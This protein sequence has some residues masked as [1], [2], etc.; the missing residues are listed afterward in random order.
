M[1]N[2]K[3]LYYAGSEFLFSTEA[4]LVNYNSWIVETILGPMDVSQKGKKVLD[5]G[6]GI[7]TLSSIFERQTGIKPEGLEI[8]PRQREILEKRGFKVYSSFNEIE[9]KYD[10]IF[11]SN[12]LEHI[13]DDV[14]ILKKLRERIQESGVLAIYVPAFQSIW[15]SLD[16][17]V[18]HYRRYTK[19]DLIMKLEKSGF[20]VSQSRYCDSVGFFLT[21]L[22]KLIGN[23]DGE[24]SSWTL[25]VFDKYLLPIS[26][27]LDGIFHRLLGKN[28]FVLAH[29]DS[30]S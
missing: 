14:E 27:V 17:K 15:S 3:Q 11:T 4:D 7:G 24:P 16:D 18:G 20:T 10:F 1:Q 2:E 5:F 23:K 12:V 28:L 30:K 13:E 9:T 8:D 22:F 21:L 25:V 19:R 6:A 26:K 29:P